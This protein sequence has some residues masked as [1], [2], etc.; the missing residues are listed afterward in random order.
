MNEEIIIISLGGSLIVPDD[1]DML[2]LKDFRNIILSQIETGKK[3]IIITGGG[4]ICRR[5]QDVAK[6]IKNISHEDLDWLGIYATRFNASFLKT[7][8]GDL[9]E[10]EIILDPSLEVKMEK[11]IILDRCS[12][13]GRKHRC[14][15]YDY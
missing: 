10:N 9:A 7:L 12:K 4:K 14:V 3:F 15:F 13:E 11:S 8:F 6:E 5:Y 2:F 1:I